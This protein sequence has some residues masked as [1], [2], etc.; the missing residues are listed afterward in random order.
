MAD[1][2]G[3]TSISEVLLIAGGKY[4]ALATS[5]QFGCADIT[6]GTYAIHGG[7][8]TGSGMTLLL[9][10]C[11]APGS[12]G[13]Y[14]PYN[15]SGYLTA[16]E[17]NVSIDVGAVLLPTLGAAMDPL[18]NVPSSLAT[19]A[20]NWNDAGNTLTINADGSF[21]EMQTSGC[22]VSGA[23]SI[24]DATHNLYAVSLQITNCASSNANIAFTGLGYLDNSNPTALSFIETLSGPDPSN[25]GGT[26]LISDTITQP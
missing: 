15:L 5:D 11:M 19:L 21:S 9:N 23:Y 2:V 4:Y 6:G 13:G 24:I 10:G 8:F 22:L 7:I 3:S 25:P 26:V 20:G 14:V 12:Q 18:Y 16:A 1:T 17:L